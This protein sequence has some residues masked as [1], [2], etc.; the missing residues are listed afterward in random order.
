MVG[1]VA[2]RRK[3]TRR[4]DTMTRLIGGLWSNTVKGI[5]VAPGRQHHTRNV[6]NTG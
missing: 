6:I 4:I 3:L 2:S 5:I 1:R